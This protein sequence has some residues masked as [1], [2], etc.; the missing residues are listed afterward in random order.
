MSTLATASGFPYPATTETADVQRDLKALADYLEAQLAWTAY[1]PVWTGSSTNPVINNGTLQ[2]AYCKIGKLVNFR[3]SI[4]LG[5]TTTVGAGA[6]GL[7]LPPVNTGAT[8]TE[9]LVTGMFYDSSTG[10]YYRGVGRLAPSGS[11]IGRAMFVDGAG[12]LAGW[13]ATVP[14]VPASGDIITFC[15]SYQSV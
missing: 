11:T 7:S 10:L 14:V 5:S 4:T 2:G 9:Q 13:S 8:V 15:G 12:S 6:Y 3:A 1:T